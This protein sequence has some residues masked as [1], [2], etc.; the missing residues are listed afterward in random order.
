M[1]STT[2]KAKMY[3]DEIKEII[4]I[5]KSYKII[6]FFQKEEREER[7]EDIMISMII[8]SSLNHQK[9]TKMNSLNRSIVEKIMRDFIIINEYKNKVWIK[10]LNRFEFT[11]IY[12]ELNIQFYDL[13][14]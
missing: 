11:K 10:Y 13:Y 2:L 3:I 7:N 5:K 9:L 4:H 1:T 14:Q 6:D 12:V 8:I